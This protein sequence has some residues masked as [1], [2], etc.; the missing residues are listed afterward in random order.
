MPLCFWNDP[1]GSKYHD[2]YF[3]AYPNVWT[4]GDYVLIHSDTG[5]VTIY[6]RSDAVLNPAGVPVVQAGVVDEG[7][8]LPPAAVARQVGRALDGQAGAAG[9]GERDH[10]RV[11]VH[12]RRALSPPW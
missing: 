3:N 9:E 4:H 7:E 10:F 6:G 12:T 2:A 5:G 11:A 1:G 8:L